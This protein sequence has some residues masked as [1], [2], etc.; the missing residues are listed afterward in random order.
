MAI[1]TFQAFLLAFLVWF[2]KASFTPN[3]TYDWFKPLPASLFVGLVMGDFQAALSAGIGLYCKV[4][5]LGS[6]I[7]I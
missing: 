6:C 7:Q 3:L 4:P 2:A 5:A 1:T